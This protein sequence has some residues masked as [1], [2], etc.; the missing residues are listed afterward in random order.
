MRIFVTGA[1]GV[2]GRRVIPALT[3]A[4]HTVTAR[5]TLAAEASDA[6]KLGRH[7][8]RRELVRSC[9]PGCRDRRQ[10]GCRNRGL[11]RSDP[12][13]VCEGRASSVKERSSRTFIT[14]AGST[15]FSRCPQSFVSRGS[16]R[17]TTSRHPSWSTANIMYYPQSG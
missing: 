5:R 11:E 6:G 10:R 8:G 17:S 9:A 15:G 16:S 7:R 13:I 1:T 2:I 14:E 4:G 3:R 12:G